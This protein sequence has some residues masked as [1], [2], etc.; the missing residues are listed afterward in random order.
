MKSLGSSDIKIYQETG[1][2][3]SFYYQVNGYESSIVKLLVTSYY[4]EQNDLVSVINRR[5]G[6]FLR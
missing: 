6:L 2:Q 4:Y 1:R 3:L 5:F